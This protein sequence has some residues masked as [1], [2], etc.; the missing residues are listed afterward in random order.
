MLHSDVKERWLTALSSANSFK[1]SPQP[2]LTSKLPKHL[3]HGVFVLITANWTS[4][5]N[6]SQSAADL[7]LASQL[8]EGMYLNTLKLSLRNFVF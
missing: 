5:A 2:L 1:S 8:R 3:S 7:S 4:T 6:S